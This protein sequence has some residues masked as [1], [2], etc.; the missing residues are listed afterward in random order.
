MIRSP[1][2]Y[3]LSETEAELSSN[4]HVT[5]AEESHDHFFSSIQPETFALGYSCLASTSKVHDNSVIINRESMQ[6]MRENEHEVA[7][8]ILNV[9]VERT[10]SVFKHDARILRSADES[11]TISQREPRYIRA[12]EVIQT[13]DILLIRD[14]SVLQQRQSVVNAITTVIFEK[15]PQ[16]N[17]LGITCLYNEKVISTKFFR[18]TLIMN[19]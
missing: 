9:N 3:A 1:L 11:V 13:N 5:H 6:K 4:V 16:R 7:E 14:Q 18:I 2:I 17:L 19:S 10:P 12:E 15:P 8:I